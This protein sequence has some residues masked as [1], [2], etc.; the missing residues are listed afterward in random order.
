MTLGK[1]QC[2]PDFV[3]YYHAMWNQS[4]QDGKFDYNGM[5]HA[6]FSVT[7]DDHKLFPELPV[8]AKVVLWEDD[9]GFVYHRVCGDANEFAD[10]YDSVYGEME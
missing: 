4:F 3:P 10:T 8:F 9:N 7:E 1:F 6:Y 2:E 5:P